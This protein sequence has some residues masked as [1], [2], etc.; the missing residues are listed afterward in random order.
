MVVRI[1][2]ENPFENIMK[3]MDPLS[4]KIHMHEILCINSG[5]YW[6][7]GHRLKM[8]DL[9]CYSPAYKVPGLL[10]QKSLNL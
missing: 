4:R 2:V 1:L 9:Q 6:A 8:P 3:A 10:D 7:M 5:L